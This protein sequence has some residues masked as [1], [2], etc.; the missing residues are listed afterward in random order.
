MTK[1]IRSVPMVFRAVHFANE[2]MAHRIE[3]KLSLTDVQELTGLSDTTIKNAENAVF[4]NMHMGNF[5]A[6][7]NVYDLD[8]REFFELKV[9]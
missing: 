9:E 8:P 5:I 7:C 3:L 4:P 1:K 6:I 2:C